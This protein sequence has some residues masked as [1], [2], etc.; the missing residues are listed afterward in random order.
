[1][2]SRGGEEGLL[3]QVSAAL[4]SDPLSRGASAR[5]GEPGAFKRSSFI[6]R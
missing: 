3:L 4:M 2:G 6:S 5:E 1:M